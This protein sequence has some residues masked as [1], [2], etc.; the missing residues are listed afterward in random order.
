MPVAV[1]GHTEHGRLFGGGERPMLPHMR[2][3]ELLAELQARLEVAL[4]TRDRVHALLE[5]VVSISGDLDLETVLRRIVEAAT[6]LVD[7]RYGAL[8]VTDEHGQLVQFLPVGVTEEEISKIESWPHGRG[9]LGLLI[10]EPQVLRLSNIGD[11]PESY[12][13]PARHPPMRSFLGVPVRVR[14]EVFGNLYLTEKR[15]G[16]DF[17]EEDE[18]VVVAIAAAAGVAIENARLYDESHRRELWLQASSEVTT[19]LLSG[20]DPPEVLDLIARR[21]RTMADADLAGIALPVPEGSSLRIES[22]DGGLADRLHDAEVPVAGTLMGRVF[23][24]GEPEILPDVRHDPSARLLGEMPLGPALLVPLGAP[25][26][27]RGVLFIANRS[28][29]LTFAKATHRMLRAF[30][31]QAAIA[32]E[33]AARRREAERLVILEDRDR[34][35]KDLHDV[36]IQR[37]FASAMTLMGAAK[38]TDKP[39]VELRVRR[40][41]DDLD[42]TIREIRS[43]IFALQAPAESPTTLRSRISAAVEAAG[44]T[45]GFVPAVHLEGPVDT[46]VPRY[47]GEQLLVVLRE[48]LSNVARHARAGRASVAV[49]VHEA[50]DPDPDDDSGA[51]SVPDGDPDTGSQVGP[52]GDPQVGPRI[53]PQISIVTLRVADD[54]VGMPATARRSGLRNLAERAESLGGGCDVESRL[55]GGTVLRWRVPLS[56]SGTE[57][58]PPS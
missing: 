13:F 47:I 52:Q 57:Q 35:A 19:A 20:T 50:T 31:D 48:A 36:V 27:I 21:A 56:G 7:A 12:G 9:L 23:T 11:H 17:D 58:D 32:L 51:D 10:K 38:L 25:R 45:L 14:G 15:G 41:V 18:A 46:A 2:L 34:I 33:L 40:A 24:S 22:A 29:R 43:T 4:A 28:G 16:G 54:G 39:E 6:G 26:E 49:A 8:G 53:G 3:D 30:A 37:L 42:E 55:D 44:E 5:A 1:R